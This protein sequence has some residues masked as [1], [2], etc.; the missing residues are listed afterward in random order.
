ME[1]DQLRAEFLQGRVV[2]ERFLVSRKKKGGEATL[3]PSFIVSRS[4]L[5]AS[6]SR[7]VLVRLANPIDF[8]NIYE[9]EAQAS[10]I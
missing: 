7:L 9:N 10:L 1:C 2:A 8:I 3:H 6:P 5:H 4:P